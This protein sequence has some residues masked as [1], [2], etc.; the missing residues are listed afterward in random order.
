MNGPQA[1][2]LLRA[3]W[4]S[5]CLCAPGTVVR[6]ATGRPAD[7]ATRRVLRVLGARHLVQAVVTGSCATAPVLAVGV[8]VDLTHASSAL[9]L[10]AVRPRR[11][12][13]GLVDAGIAL[14]WAALGRRD[15]A[16]TGDV[17]Q[18]ADAR[19]RTAA[20]LLQRLHGSRLLTGWG[21]APRG[22]TR[23]ESPG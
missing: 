11:R 17:R 16:A 10:A 23:A 14:S 18:P 6:L 8:L 4:G 7:V 15:V 3:G 13:E 20:A 22:P 5:A 19:S 12:R 9:A 21:A 2:Q 1:S